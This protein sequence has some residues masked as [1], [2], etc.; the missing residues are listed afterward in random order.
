MEL[1]GHGAGLGRRVR[2]TGGTR[3]VQKPAAAEVPAGHSFDGRGAWRSV[4]PRSRRL[5]S[6]A[7]HT[8][9]EAVQ[10]K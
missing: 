1:A 8:P 4:T 9:I 7:M 2:R 5:A 10:M 6:F 3:Y